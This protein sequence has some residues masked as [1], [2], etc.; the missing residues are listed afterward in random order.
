VL[1]LKD[2]ALSIGPADAEQTL[3]SEITLRVPAGHFAAVLG[4]SGC[5]KSTLLKV[6]AGIREHTIGTIHWN[7]RDLATEKDMDP[8]EVGYVPQFSIAHELLTVEECVDGALRLRVADLTPELR[9]ERVTKVLQSVGLEEI[10]DR[11]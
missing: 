4:P 5:G 10:A 11:R 6:I 2:L 3:L 8:H 1:E 9:E 7:G